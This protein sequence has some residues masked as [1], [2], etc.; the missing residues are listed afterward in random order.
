MTI[1]KGSTS[2]RKKGL[3]DETDV[4]AARLVEEGRGYE[5]V[6]WSWCAN[7]RM[8]TR[9]SETIEPKRAPWSCA[10]TSG[11]QTETVIEQPV[12]SSIAIV[13]PL[14]LRIGVGAAQSLPRKYTQANSGNMLMTAIDAKGIPV[15]WPPRNERKWYPFRTAMNGVAGVTVR[16]KHTGREPPM[17]SCR[18]GGS[19]GAPPELLSSSDSCEA[20]FEEPSSS[21]END[22]RSLASIMPPS[23]WDA[24]SS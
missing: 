14:W 18:S 21:S 15:T 11:G 1:S 8:N 19:G 24:A 5:T 2:K 12:S 23:E 16:A 4:E 17:S 9:C 22:G 6:S 3:I 20:M 13:N 7:S 10:T